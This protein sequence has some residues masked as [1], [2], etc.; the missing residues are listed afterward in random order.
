MFHELA[1]ALQGLWILR[2]SRWGLITRTVRT[3]W[4][5]ISERLS[6]DHE[7]EMDV[8]NV[9]AIQARR[10]VLTLGM[11]LTGWGLMSAFIFTAV[12]DLGLVDLTPANQVVQPVML[13]LGVL[14]L[15]GAAAHWYGSRR[16]IRR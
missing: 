7:S 10:R 13:G 11:V 6:T 2:P 15:L 9:R 1:A 12:E 4:A 14:L 8:R 16:S 3:I 5:I